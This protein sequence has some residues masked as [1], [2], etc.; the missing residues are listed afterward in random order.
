M[1]QVLNNAI[2]TYELEDRELDERDP[3]GPF[4]AA[5]AYAI[6]STFHITLRASPGQ[7]VFGRD[8]FLPLAFKADWAMIHA[9]KQQEMDKNNARENA[10][11]I[12]HEYNV[13]DKV[14]LTVPTKQAKHRQF[15]EGPY[16]IEKVSANGNIHIRR[17]ATL[18]RINI[19]RVTPFFE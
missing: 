2:R 11:R 17:G 5:A 19:R 15:R 18:D 1:H 9:R 6:R 13:G 7:L 10:K 3:F 14:L 4:L 12:P 16:T 8:M